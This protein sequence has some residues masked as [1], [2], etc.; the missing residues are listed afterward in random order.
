MPILHFAIKRCVPQMLHV[1]LPY[2]NDTVNVSKLAD[3]VV[4]ADTHSTVSRRGRR[5]SQPT[6]LHL[7]HA[8]CLC[9]FKINTTG[10]QHVGFSPRILHTGDW[11]D[12]SS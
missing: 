4:F 5:L 9:G 2:F 3:I 6:A 11:Y 7:G 8:C 12:C 10:D 1:S